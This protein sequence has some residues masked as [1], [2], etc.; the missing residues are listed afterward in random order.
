MRVLNKRIVQLRTCK[1]SATFVSWLILYAGGGC[2]EPDCH[3]ICDRVEFGQPLFVHIELLKDSVDVSDSTQAVTF[4]LAFSHLQSSVRAW[5]VL[6]TGPDSSVTPLDVSANASGIWEFQ[7]STNALSGQHYIS[8]VQWE[9]L[10]S[11]DGLVG[12]QWSSGRPPR[13]GPTIAPYMVTNRD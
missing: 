12:D 8:S 2:T 10:A 7:V 6:S 5:G 13:L 4:T 3:P 1:V 11:T 9:Y